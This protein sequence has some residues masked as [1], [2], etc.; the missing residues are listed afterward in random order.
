MPALKKTDSPALK[1]A[2]PAAVPAQEAEPV[3]KTP[4]KKP[5]ARKSSAKAPAV[6][7]IVEHHGRQIGTEAV[8]ETAAKL[9]TLAGHDAADIK[10]VE[11]YVKQEDGVIYCVVNGEAVGKYDL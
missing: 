6:S 8:A 2:K 11:L 5:A 1:K 3:K 4:A 10:T 7:V 9:W